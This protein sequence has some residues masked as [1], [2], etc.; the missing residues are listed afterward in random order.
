MIIE[1]IITG[2]FVENSWILGDSQTR[3]AIIFDPGDNAST[4]VAKLSELGL[5][6]IFILNT[7]AHPDH[8]GAAAELQK[9]FELLFAIHEDD[10]P[11]FNSA[12]DTAQLLGLPNFQIP[13]ITNFL[14]DGQLLEI[15]SHHLQVM[16]TPGHTP[17]SVCFLTGK[18]LFSGDTLFQ[19]SIGRTDLPGGSSRQITASLKRLRQLPEDTRIYPGHGE[20]TTIRKELETNPFFQE[21]K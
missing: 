2:P 17:G 9:R 6:P 21:I 7:H 13:E 11:I 8:I 14:H 3:H 4:I 18:H 12:R 5:T 20:T 16:H 10:I 15:N 19:G 1:S